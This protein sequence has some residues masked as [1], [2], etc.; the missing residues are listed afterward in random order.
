PMWVYVAGH[1]LTHAIAGLLCGS[2]PRSIKIKSS[3]GKVEL[4]RTNTFITLAPYLVP[5]YT[6]AW[7]ALV[8]LLH[9]F[10]AVRITLF[11]VSFGIG[12][13]Y[14]FHV[15]LTT[16]ILRLQ[17]PDFVAEGQYLSFVLTILGN[18][19][20]LLVAAGCLGSRLTVG[21]ELT[22]WGIETLAMVR[23]VAQFVF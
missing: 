11:W 5:I 22:A 8:V 3:G 4:P 9:W 18:L 15:T 12:A 16:Y 19:L 6:L 21:G 23:A 1:E 2:V 20:F 17:Q 10:F 14:A 13:T 7:C